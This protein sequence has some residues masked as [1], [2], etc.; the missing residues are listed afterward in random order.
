MA[1]GSTFAI[2]HAVAAIAFNRPRE[3][4]ETLV[5]LDPTVGLVRDNPR[6]WDWLTISRHLSGQHARELRETRRGQALLGPG[7]MLAAEVRALAALGRVSELDALIDANLS[8]PP[9]HPAG[10]PGDLMRGAAAELR[11][12]GNAEAAARTLEKAI[13][14]Y[15]SRPEQEQPR[16]RNALARTL[17]NAERWAEACTLLAELAAE[18]PGSI[19][20][21][22]QLGVIAAR[23]GERAEADRISA[24][25]AASAQ[26]LSRGTHTLWRARIAAQLDQHEQAV[27]LLR[28]ALSEGFSH[29][30]WLHTDADFAPLRDDRAFQEVV[31]PGG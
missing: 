4:L 12:H 11:A 26:P 14:W 21:L 17:Y 16:H 6:Y 18:Q 9:R 10:T 24:M 23:Q 27:H 25:L 15:R 19:N 13:A 28:E 20:V 3:A 29:G 2:G 31:R 7:S 22:G 5:R 1:P 30:M 8:L